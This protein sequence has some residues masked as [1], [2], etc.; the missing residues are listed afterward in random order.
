[1][2]TNYAPVSW[3]YEWPC[4]VLEGAQVVATVHCVDGTTETAAIN[5]RLI[6][7]VPKPNDWLT[8]NYRRP[9]GRLAKLFDG[10]SVS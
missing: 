4:T 8:L 5:A 1:M 9:C 2:K 7:A 3:R 6:A 10:I